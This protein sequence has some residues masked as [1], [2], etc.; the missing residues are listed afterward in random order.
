[1][2]VIYI[3][4]KIENGKFSI[5]MDGLLNYCWIYKSTEGWREEFWYS[6]FVYKDLVTV[7]EGKEK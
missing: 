4:A 3:V 7:C 2:E 5:E 1:M 6:Y